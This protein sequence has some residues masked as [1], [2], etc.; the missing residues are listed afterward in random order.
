MTNFYI[1][2]TSI[3]L[4][5]LDQGSKFLVRNFLVQDFEITSFFR[6]TFVENDGIAF[7]VPIPLLFV[8]PLT[9]VVLFYLCKKLLEK[10]LVVY[11]K[12]AFLL[13]FSG[14]VGNL[15][16]RVIFGSVTDFFSFWSF[17]VFNFADSFISLGVGVFLVYSLF[18]QRKRPSRHCL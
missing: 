10:N 14:A 15:I 5:F 1:F 17:P 8:I 16:D 4:V 13:I 3:G 9:C 11:E 2:F 6:L 12:I 7:S 18:L